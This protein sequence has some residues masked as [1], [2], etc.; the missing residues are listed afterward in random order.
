MAPRDVIGVEHAFVV[1]VVGRDALI[2]ER[3]S[4]GGVAGAGDFAGDI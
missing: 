4:A 3:C 1:G 2:R